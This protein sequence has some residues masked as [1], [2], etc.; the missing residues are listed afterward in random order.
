M[1]IRWK[2]KPRVDVWDWKYT[3]RH[4]GEP[5]PLLLVAYLVESKRINGKPRQKTRYLAS[6][7]EKDIAKPLGRLDFW[8]SVQAKIAPLNLSTEQQ[9]AIKQGL[10]KRVP[11][12]TQEQVDSVNK[13]LAELTARMKA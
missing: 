4:K 6:I 3:G 13:E 12:V 11:D 10:L 7:W 5:Q 8:K 2:D 1:Y 9:Q